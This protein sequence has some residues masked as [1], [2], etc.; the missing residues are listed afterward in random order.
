MWAARVTLEARFHDCRTTGGE[1]RA[2]GLRAP[3]PR[4][5]PLCLAAH[6][7]A[8]ACMLLASFAVA[9]LAATLGRPHEC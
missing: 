8:A 7:A 4:A 5:P 6:A 3:P 2:P 1:K 9:Y